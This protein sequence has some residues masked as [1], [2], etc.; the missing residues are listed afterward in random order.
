MLTYARFTK[1][2]QFSSDFKRLEAVKQPDAA[3]LLDGHNEAL[4]KT[5]NQALSIEVFNP[6]IA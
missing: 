2:S 1:Q 4:G 3:W 5:G 6:W